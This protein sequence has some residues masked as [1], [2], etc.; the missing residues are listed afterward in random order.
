MKGEIAMSQRLPESALPKCGS[1]LSKVQSGSAE[2]I[3][4]EKYNERG[5]RL[6]YQCHGKSETYDITRDFFDQYGHVPFVEVAFEVRQEAV[7][8]LNA[9]EAIASK[10]ADQYRANSDKVAEFIESTI[11]TI[12]ASQSTYK[13][14]VSEWCSRHNLRLEMPYASILDRSARVFEL[15]VGPKTVLGKFVLPFYSNESDVKWIPTEKK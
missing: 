6:T 5:I 8:V 10:V 11:K 12:V 14:D 7:P 13:G 1:C 15:S 3:V 2:P 4:D 9:G